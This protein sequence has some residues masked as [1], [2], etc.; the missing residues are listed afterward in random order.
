MA[1]SCKGCILAL[2]R[3]DSL[4]QRYANTLQVALISY[5][6]K[7]RAEHFFKEN[8]IGKT[9]HL[10]MVTD[11]KTF[12]KYF[13]H[14]YISHV[15]W[16]QKK[17][18]KAISWTDYVTDNNVQIFLRGEAL[19]VPV[20]RDI[21]PFDQQ[22]NLLTLNREKIPTFSEPILKYY[23]AVTS[24]MPYQLPHIKRT[25]DSANGTVHFN[26]ENH[27]I[28]ELY[29]S[30]ANVSP[31]PSSSLLFD[32]KDTSKYLYQPKLGYKDTWDSMN[33]YC[34]DAVFPLSLS[35]EAIKEKMWSDFNLFFGIQVKLERRRTDCLHLID[36]SAATPGEKGE[37]LEE[38]KGD[39]RLMLTVNDILWSVNRCIIG[40]PVINDNVSGCKGPFYIRLN[41]SPIELA[42]D[43][44][45]YGI[46]VKKMPDEADMFILSENKRA[47]N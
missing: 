38:R 3:L 18:V 36:T 16:V 32:V 19:S 21:D 40:T 15:I 39:K 34:Y 1:T 43:L 26:F 24:Y 7:A 42:E 31:L 44:R 8:H 33:Q 12:T 45:P 30:A 35:E 47:V 6:P 17:E 46:A 13:P 25:V 23:S 20:K 2:P 41:G 22:E 29:F 10:P 28:P 14:Q 5:E 11:D 27:Y 9:V 4:Q 37:N